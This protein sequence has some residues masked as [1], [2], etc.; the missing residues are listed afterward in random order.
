M[1][2]KGSFNVIQNWPF[3]VF[4]ILYSIYT[5][6]STDHYHPAWGGDYSLYVAHAKNIVLGHPYEETNYL[7]NPF[8]SLSPPT[9]PPGTSWLLAPFYAV[10]GLDFQ[11]L[12]IAI[13]LSLCGAL[14]FVYLFV[15]RIAEKN[16]ALLTTVLFS[17]TPALWVSK[18]Y[19]NSE[20]LFILFSFAVLWLVEIKETR[21]NFASYIFVSVL[22]SVFIY[23]AYATRSIGIVLLLALFVF[24][25][26][27]S[28]L[29]LRTRQRALASLAIP[30]LVFCL[31]YYLQRAFISSDVGYSDQ[32]A[33][34][35]S[36]KILEI[37]LNNFVHYVKNVGYLYIPLQDGDEDTY[38][39]FRAMIS[40]CLLAL[41]LAGLV[42][43]IVGG[44]S[45]STE[46]N[47]KVAA[48]SFFRS[49]EF[50]QIY[51]VGYVALLLIVPIRGGDRYLM[52]I[53]PLM[54][55]Y[56]SLA[57][58][59]VARKYSIRKA[60]QWSAVVSL[61]LLLIY[62]D[63][64][65]Q[66][67]ARDVNEADLQ[68]LFAF[69]VRSLP[70]ASVIGFGKPRVLA[71]FTER[72]SFRWPDQCALSFDDEPDKPCPT[73]WPN[74]ER[75]K[76]VGQYF[77]YVGATH[78]IT[79]NEISGPTR[80]QFILRDIKNLDE[81]TELLYES[82]T[83]KVFSIRTS[84]LPAPP[85]SWNASTVPDASQCAAIRSAKSAP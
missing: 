78:L 77:R 46:T 4:V 65:I 2:S 33:Q 81:L 72:C 25:V 52:P 79:S 55:F 54:L 39:L 6:A 57:L 41:A 69:V 7:Y 24:E 64:R 67:L 63:T 1:I 60:L 23:L 73:A 34:T 51:L 28:A 44:F 14:V 37:A 80:K 50:H 74:T 42:L 40:V 62:G 56:I 8:N 36:P 15:L 29:L 31:L 75:D 58:D 68:S 38:F 76:F 83:Y 22:L 59:D 10:W 27:R 19:I 48:Q 61:V 45:V 82:K 5:I 20:F 66:R 43:R 26:I 17:L 3:F 16:L 18:D 53:A 13:A 12:K 85:V 30:F 11:K 32:I 71:L 21:K 47:A 35:F 70:D 49:I 84:D 9:Y